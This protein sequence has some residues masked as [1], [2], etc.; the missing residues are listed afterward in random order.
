MKY[1]KPT[2]T[3]F[4]ERAVLESAEVKVSSPPPSAWSCVRG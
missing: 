4:D 2:I 3:S 1:E